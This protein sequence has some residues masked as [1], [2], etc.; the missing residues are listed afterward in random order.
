MAYLYR[1]IRLDKNVPFYI[2]IGVDNNYYRANTKKSR[3]NHWNSIVEKTDYE[4]EILFEHDDYEFIKE[5]EIEFIS[6]HG[7][8]DLGL[9]TLCNKTNGG[10]GCVGLVHSDEAKLKMSLPNR[11]KIISE[12]HRRKISEFHKGRIRSKECREKISLANK[13]EKS[14][15]FGKKASEETRAKMKISSKKGEENYSSF[16]KND[17]I[18]NIREMY[19]SK[20]YSS[21]KLAKMFNVSKTNILSIVNY[22]TWKHII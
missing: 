14:Y 6:L 12:E 9:G 15:M 18:L 19:K 13:G 1:H 7:R 2:G 4:V 20:S 16:L 3:N 8:S 21:R 17:D 22:K 10:D 5:K 11:G